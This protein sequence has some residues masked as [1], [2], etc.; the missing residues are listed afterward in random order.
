MD[1]SFVYNPIIN[2]LTVYNDGKQN[3]R[4]LNLAITRPW[5]GGLHNQK[6]GKIVNENSKPKLNYYKL[7]AITLIGKINK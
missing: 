5:G 7:G 3:A 6:P 2:Q 1:L 4:N